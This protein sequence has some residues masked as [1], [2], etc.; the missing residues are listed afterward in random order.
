L[1]TEQA[2]FTALPISRFSHSTAYQFFQPLN[3]ISPLIQYAKDDLC[4]PD[5]TK[6]PARVDDLRTAVALD[7]DYDTISHALKLTAQWPRQR[8]T[9]RIA[10]HPTYRT[11][12]GVLHPDLPPTLEPHE[13]GI[14]GHLTVMGQHKT[15]QITAFAFPSRH[16]HAEGSFS[17]AFVQPPGL[18][19]TLRLSIKSRVPPFGESCAPHAYFTL[20]KAIFADRYQL[21]DPLFLA[22]KNISALRHMTQPVDLEAPAY[23]MRPWGSGVLLELATSGSHEWSAEVPLHLRYLE[24]V[25]GGYRDI[26]I[27]YPVVF[28]ACTAEEGTKF[29]T[30]PFDRVNLGYDGLFG[31]RT[32]FWHLDP[33]PEGGR[34]TLLNSIRVPVLDTDRGGW[35]NVGT[36]VVVFLGF[37]YVVLKLV[38]AYLRAGYI[39]HE[40]AAAEKKKQ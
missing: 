19:P 29:P 38:Q 5:D 24:P 18:H 2:S 34:K 13:L 15:P 11:E 17:A 35:V 9:L 22:S 12:V 7:I 23:A 16:R 40:K 30:N 37:A 33:K 3:D 26:E 20:P 14:A 28:W 39:G 32:V 8:Q 36:A 27:P 21:E 10:S 25:A 6:C 31:P 4:P 1:L